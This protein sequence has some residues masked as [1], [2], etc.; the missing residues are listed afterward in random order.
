MS[1]SLLH[2]DD[3]VAWAA[4]LELIHRPP[5]R[6]TLEHRWRTPQ[7]WR[8][9]AWDL[10]AQHDA[11]GKVVALKATGSDV[12]QRRLAE[13]QFLRLACAVEQSPV[14]ILITDPEGRVQYVNR[15]FTESSGH[16]MEDILDQNLDPLR[17]G[18]ADEEAYQRFWQTL[19]STGEW[20]G[21]L[22]LA[23]RQGKTVCESVRVSSIRNEA[24]EITNRLCLREDITDRKQLE[25]Q[26]RQS[27]KM[28]S[29]G[30]LAGGIAHDFNNM[31]AIIHGYAELCLNRVG[32]QDEKMRKYLRE[33][34]SAAQRACGLVRQILIFSRKT[35]VHFTL[36][37][38][39]QL[40][41]ELTALMGETFPRTIAFDIDLDD[42]LPDLRGDQNSCSRSS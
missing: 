16:S 14:A 13:E 31:L 3:A 4:A 32:D 26:L 5:H 8:W 28:E 22:Y 21:E 36:V 39:P 7:G 2:P 10:S 35:E 41:R 19:R 1:A 30:T 23:Q 25:E 18:H 40:V 17:T 29:L 11:R 6:S 24:G 42:T 9:I 15:K 33:V 37:S 20:S 38:L 34:H 12:T 27:Q